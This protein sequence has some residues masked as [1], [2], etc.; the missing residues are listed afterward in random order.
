MAAITPTTTTST[1]DASTTTS[2]LPRALSSLR[3][4]TVGVGLIAATVTTAVAATVHAAGVSFEIDGEMIPLL[5][6]AQMAFLGAVIG[7]LLAGSFN[8]RSAHPHRRFLQVTAA[9]T[10]LSCIPSVALPPALGT[11]LGLVLAHLV[12]AAIVVPVLARRLAD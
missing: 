8:K 4:V 5:G 10:V 3:K 2:P 9:L 6:F 11:K 12:A 7:G 1:P